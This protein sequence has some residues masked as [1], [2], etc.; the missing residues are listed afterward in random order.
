MQRW[1]VAFANP[2]RDEIDL[3]GNA[4]SEKIT[5]I[6][7][8]FRHAIV[9]IEIFPESGFNL[10]LGYNFRR[11]EELRILEQRSF[12]GLSGGFSIK[13]NKLRLSYAYSK[14]NSAAASSFF[15]LNINLQ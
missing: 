9:G 7:N 6:D 13:L 11:G 3:E 4:T 2:N 5:F 1:N 14:Y 8:L 10:R 15:G 12:A